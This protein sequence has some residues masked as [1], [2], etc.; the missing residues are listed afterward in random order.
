MLNCRKLLFAAVLSSV[1]TIAVALEPGDPDPLFADVSPIEITITGP[2]KTLL[3][4][5]PNDTYLRGTLS[6]QEL[7]GKIVEFDVFTSTS[8]GCT[9]MCTSSSPSLRLRSI[10]DIAFDGTT[11][12]R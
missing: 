5:R 7:D 10:N 12:E 9:A 4:E 3:G 1:A 8:L 2:M 6:Y 11:G